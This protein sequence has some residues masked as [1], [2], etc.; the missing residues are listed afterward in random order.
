MNDAVQADM[1][2]FNDFMAANADVEEGGTDSPS[3]TFE[4]AGLEARNWEKVSVAVTGVTDGAS[5]FQSGGPGDDVLVGGDGSDFQIGGAGDDTLDGGLGGDVLVGGEGND[6]LSGGDGDDVLQGGDGDDVVFGGEGND[7]IVG[8][9]GHGDDVYH[10]GVGIDTVKYT[11]ATQPIEVDL[12]AGTA[13]GPEIGNDTLID[14]E[15]VIGGQGADTIAGDAGSNVLDGYTGDDYL[16]GRGGDVVV[17][18]GAGFDTAEF[19]GSLFDH[20]YTQRGNGSWI[21]EDLDP[22]DGGDDG[23]DTL[24]SVERMVF[25][26]GEIFLDG[27]NNAAFTRADELTS[28][29]DT[30]IDFS[31]TLLLE[32]D[33]DF[34]G[35]TLTIVAIDTTETQGAVQD[36][37]G[38][39]YRYDPSQAFQYL[40]VGES[41][42]DSFFYTVSDGQAGLT[43]EI[44]TVTVTGTNDGPVIGAADT[45]GAV[46]EITDLAT[47]ENTATLS[48]SGTIAFTDVDL[49]DTH[50]VSVT[51]VGGGAGYRGSLVASVTDASTGDG[52]GQMTWTFSVADAAID[53]LAAGQVLTQSYDVTVDDANGGK[54]T[55][56]VTITIT[57]TQDL[58]LIGGTA[59][60]TLTETDAA[61][62]ASGQLTI[63]DADAGESA[64]RP[65][66]GTAG[67]YGSFSVGAG[68]AW[69]YDLDATAAD[70]LNEGQVETETFT[71]LSVDGTATTVT[72]T[73]TG[74]NDAPVANEDSGTTEEGKTYGIDVLANDTDVDRDDEHTVDTV[75]VVSGLGA[76]S[77]VDNQVVYD[78]GTAYDYLA[79]GEQA[80]IEIAY[81]MSDSQGS[82]S[83]STVTVTV[84]GKDT[85]IGTAGDDTINTGVGNDF[86]YG[87]GTGTVYYGG[88]DTLSA[89]GGNDYL[90][91]DTSYYSYVGGNDI[92]SG[93]SGTDY[94]LGD[95]WTYSYYGGR[96]YLYGGADTDYLYGD[97]HDYAYYGGSDYLYGG[98]G[99]DY[100]YGDASYYSY[101]GGDDTLSGDAGTDYLLGD[102]WTY[103]WYGGRET[104]YGGSGGDYGMSRAL[105]KS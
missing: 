23:T 36:L 69:T 40:A 92:L 59:S 58:P 9:S 84:T 38:E 47:G 56:T 76:V 13:S 81:T 100:L 90:Y 24:K 72:V 51:P 82:E 7:L 17:K 74:T 50:T 27:R 95:A 99:N 30:G 15:N 97:A 18:G 5:E 78:P 61:Q 37:G 45:A 14:I 25:R 68:G 60:D 98:T 85:H 10:G 83:S 63:T 12:E 101:D 54:D 8:G 20:G 67:T 2:G 34:E 88:N 105:L 57:G 71:V 73:I 65:Q 48:A 31:A 75:T 89:D 28:D 33:F 93:G 1:A 46:T 41:A 87:D 19:A 94:L 42:T 4:S 64:F 44:V 80:T 77:I 103:S 21:V 3:Y 96:D 26:D 16:T 29:E 49:T 104:L 53:D 35:D 91:G 70:A 22:V 62:Q 6:T 55:E 86:L 52:A 39:N 43:T 11:S 79:E 32:N 66:T 102:A